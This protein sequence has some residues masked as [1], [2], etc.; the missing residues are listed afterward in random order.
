MKNCQLPFYMCSWVHVSFNFDLRCVFSFY[1]LSMKLSSTKLF[2][3]IDKKHTHTFNCKRLHFLIHVHV[4]KCINVFLVHVKNFIYL[5]LK[6]QN[7]FWFELCTWA[8]LLILRFPY[9]ISQ[10]TP[11]YDI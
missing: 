11:Q 5:N 3:V 9:P 7:Y 8:I 6:T 4:Y 2:K 1:L 10:N